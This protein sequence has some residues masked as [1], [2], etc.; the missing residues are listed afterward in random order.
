[1][2]SGDV[3]STKLSSIIAPNHKGEYAEFVTV[4]T[5]LD[6]SVQYQISTRVK[7]K[8]HGGTTVD[9][10]DGP[11]WLF[12]PPRRSVLEEGRNLTLHCA[13]LMARGKDSTRVL[14]HWQ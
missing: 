11:D 12:I 4:F 8:N 10:I 6:G 1:M 3:S 9:N 5:S 7:I 14:C 13:L 2:K